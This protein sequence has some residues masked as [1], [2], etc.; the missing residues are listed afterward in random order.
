MLIWMK[1][2]YLKF[3]TLIKYI[4]HHFFFTR[5]QWKALAN[6]LLKYKCSV[7]II[8]LVCHQPIKKTKLVCD[9]LSQILPSNIVFSKSFLVTLANLQY[10]HPSLQ[11][12]PLVFNF[13]FFLCQNHILLSLEVTCLP[14]FFP[15]FQERYE[16]LTP[17]IWPG[18]I[19]KGYNETKC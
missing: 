6:M 7:C 10:H 14:P 1:L 8:P 4:F 3:L 15:G 19:N 11:Y 13:L 17:I 5:M 12:S 9:D 16:Q 2:I 18:I